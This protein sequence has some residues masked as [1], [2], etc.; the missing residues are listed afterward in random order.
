MRLSCIYRKIG[1][2]NGATLIE[3]MVASA[4]TFLIIFM[5]YDMLAAA[6]R[7]YVKI[8]T[9]QEITDHSLYAMVRLTRELEETSAR[10]IHIDSDPPGIVFASPRDL[11]GNFNYNPMGGPSWTKYVCLY[12]DSSTRKLMKVDELLPG[13][14]VSSPPQIPPT[15]NTTFFAT[16]S[17]PKTVLAR[18]IAYFEITGTKPLSVSLECSKQ[19]FGKTYSTKITTEVTPKN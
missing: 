18:D 9:M 3:I 2:H 19:I 14:H 10:S 8:Q 5:A 12:W 7:Y 16:S 17:Y 15:R 6:R 11:Q 1:P 4:V 13:G